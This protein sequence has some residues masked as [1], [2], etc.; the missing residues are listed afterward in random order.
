MTSSQISLPSILSRKVQQL[1]LWNIIPKN[2]KLK[3][4]QNEGKTTDSAQQVLRGINH[5]HR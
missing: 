2:G 3:A 4:Q 5:I 1:P